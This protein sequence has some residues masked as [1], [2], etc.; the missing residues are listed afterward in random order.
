VDLLVLHEGQVL[1]DSVDQVV[2]PLGWG[3]D[4]E[5][6]MQHSLEDERARGHYV[7][8]LL[9]SPEDV[10]EGLLQEMEHY[11][12]SGNLLVSLQASLEYDSDC[13]VGVGRVF[14]G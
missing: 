3:L 6:A 7:A 12:V 9:L 2:G 11:W 1:V 13:W 14:V 4:D 8:K 10:E 5:S